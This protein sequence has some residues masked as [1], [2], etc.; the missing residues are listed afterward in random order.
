MK[1]KQNK[2]LLLMTVA[3]FL[4]Y[5]PWY[6]YSAVMSYISA[7]FMLTS[8]QESMIVSIFQLG[9]VVIVLVTGWLADKVGS[10]RVVAVATLCT[11]IFSTLFVFIAHDFKTTLIMR[12]LTG[13]SAGAIYAPGMSLLSNWFPPSS[14][15]KALGTYTAGMV[16][17]YAGGYFIASPLAAVYGW[18]CGMLATSVPVFVAAIITLIFI[19]ERPETVDAPEFD[20]VKGNESDHVSLKAPVLITGS[21]MG[22]MWELYAFWGYIGS[23]L[24]VVCTIHGLSPATGG[25][26]AA[27][28]ILCGA[29][30][31]SILGIVADKLGKE[32]AIIISATASLVPELFFGYMI[33]APMGLI[34]LVSFW[35][36][37]WVIADSAIYKAA[38]TEMVSE[39]NRGTILGLQSAVGFSMTV[40]APLVF[41]AM[42][43]KINGGVPTAEA[44]NWGPC[45][46]MLGIVAI[47]SPIFAYLTKRLTNK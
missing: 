33:D 31:V 18:R 25:F 26:L 44:T 28:T 16:V 9:Y 34:L 36:G 20:G 42:L 38:L 5:L 35:I 7:E 6:N 11:A 14:R 4:G 39:K 21:Y 43:S 19:S 8:M 29:P 46:A 47:L 32:K 12:L 10:K 1:L 40:I 37:F 27:I 23:F 17:S 22:H 13:L 24:T 2:I 15:G 41:G 30:A 45:F 3:L